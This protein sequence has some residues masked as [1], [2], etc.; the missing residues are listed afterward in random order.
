[1]CYRCSNFIFS[2]TNDIV[3]SSQILLKSFTCGVGSIDEGILIVT[4]RI[5]VIRLR[6]VTHDVEHK[7]KQDG[8]R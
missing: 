2:V 1:M 6:W 7:V 4:C 8:I 5:S 3:Y